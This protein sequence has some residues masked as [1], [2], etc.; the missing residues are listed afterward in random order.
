MKTS[1]KPCRK[2]K[3]KKLTGGVQATELFSEMWECEKCH[4]YRIETVKVVRL[5]NLFDVNP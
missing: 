4:W 3:W 2:H 5:K 1:L